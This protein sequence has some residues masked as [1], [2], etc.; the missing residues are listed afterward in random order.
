M[1][2]IL[3]RVS[4]AQV[5]VDNQVI[6]CISGGLLLLVGIE[7]QDSAKDINWLIRK[8]IN[9]RIFDDEAGVMNRSI[10]D[11]Q[12]DIL[13]VSQFTLFASTKKGNRP[14]YHRA[15]AGL[16]AEP[17]FHAFTQALSTTLGKP[18]LTGQFG[19]PMQV[20]LT[21]EGPVTLFL[22]STAPE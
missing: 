22:D 15:L 2:I 11:T 3:Q 12:Q 18:V 6:S 14:S 13:A 5:S 8:I 10:I 7:A 17:I 9:L 21:N 4:H 19:A 16:A 1:R 20:R